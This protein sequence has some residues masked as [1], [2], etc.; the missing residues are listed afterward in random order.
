MH[1]SKSEQ[2]IEEDPYLLLGFGMT[3]Y[4]EIMI[5]LMSMMIFI[6]VFAGGLMHVF[7]RYD[8]L[9]SKNGF[10]LFSMGNMGAAQSICQVQQLHE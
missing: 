9:A 2:R 7:S 3:S 5:S 8:A 6:A 1:V 10:H 4:F